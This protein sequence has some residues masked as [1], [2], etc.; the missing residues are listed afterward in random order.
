MLVPFPLAAVT[1][2]AVISAAVTPAAVTSAAV[3][4]VAVTSAAVTPA[5]GTIPDRTQKAEIS[6]ISNKMLRSFYWISLRRPLLEP[7][8]C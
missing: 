2:P 7:K 3:T 5:A 4:P 6:D 8:I 1:L